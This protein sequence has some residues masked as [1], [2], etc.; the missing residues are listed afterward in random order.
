MNAKV[1][2]ENNFWCEPHFAP[3]IPNPDQGKLSEYIFSRI[4][5]EL[6]FSKKNGYFKETKAYEFSFF[7]IEIMFYLPG[8][9]FSAEIF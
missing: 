6:R 2:I 5:F 8:I 4:P 1:D 9:R 7:E 3:Q